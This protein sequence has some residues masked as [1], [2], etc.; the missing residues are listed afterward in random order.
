MSAPLPEA[1]RTRFQ[2]LIKEGYSGRAA[3]LFNVSPFGTYLL[4]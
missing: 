3:A 4:N 1:L 2:E